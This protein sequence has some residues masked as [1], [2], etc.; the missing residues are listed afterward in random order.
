MNQRHP[1]SFISDLRGSGDV[2]AAVPPADDALETSRLATPISADSSAQTTPASRMP[3]TSA[4][5]RKHSAVGPRQL[6]VIGAGLSLRER[7]IL[8]EL[9]SHR[10]LTSYHLASLVFTD[11]ASAATGQRVCRRVLARL[12]RDRLVQSLGRRVGGYQ[13]GSA[14]TVWQLAPAGARLI[15]RATQG[16]YRPTEPSPRVLQHCLAVA[17]TRLSLL[18]LTAMDMV[19]DVEVQLEPECWRRYSGLAG[20]SRW[21]QPDLAAVVVGQDRAGAFEDRWFIEVDLGTESVATLH[22]KSRT[23]AEYRAT[24]VE[25]ADSG[26]VFPLVL[27]PLSGDAAEQRITQLQAK[28]ERD[29]RLE[30]ALYRYAT[31]AIFSS[32]LLGDLS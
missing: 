23:Y 12:R 20:E 30:P 21:L 32:V 24:G 13:G 9:A 18:A 26:G 7:H 5:R 25:Q 28:I 1:Y 10:Y 22:R 14:A 29:R 27:W 11:H 3:E 6:K 2:P 4:G 31:P 15:Q 16:R 19:D 17:D 8:A